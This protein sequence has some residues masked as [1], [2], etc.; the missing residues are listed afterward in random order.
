VP[1]SECISLP[2]GNLINNVNGLTILTSVTLVIIQHVFND[3][4]Q[5]TTHINTKYEKLNLP[6]NTENT[7]AY[8]SNIRNNLDN[9]LTRLEKHLGLAESI[10]TGIIDILFGFL[11]AYAAIH[12]FIDCS[13][14]EYKY[15]ANSVAVISAFFLLL[16][17][18]SFAFIIY[19]RHSRK[20]I[21]QIEYII[22]S[23]RDRTNH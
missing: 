16:M 15:V 11:C 23:L 5:N 21:K 20:Y 6:R 13:I 14:F 22:L 18:A 8:L 12:F 9:L 10:K 17:I 7:P 19:V 4:K 1:T 2:V 3:F